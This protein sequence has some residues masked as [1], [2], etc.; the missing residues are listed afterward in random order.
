MGELCFLLSTE[1]CTWQQRFY[2]CVWLIDL[3]ARHAE[4]CPGTH[5]LL[6]SLLPP[7]LSPGIA[8]WMGCSVQDHVEPL[9]Q[10]QCQDQPLGKIAK[11]QRMFSLTLFFT[12]F[13]SPLST[14]SSSMHF[15]RESVSL[16]NA[17]AYC[18]L[19]LTPCMASTF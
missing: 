1:R 6:S 11:W 12:I 3:C 17:K 13:P 18:K 4:F 16:I 14:L 7:P 8:S 19:H 10:T 2:N 15:R 5:S 9:T